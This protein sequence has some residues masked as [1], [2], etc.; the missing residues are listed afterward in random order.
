M[1]LV[2]F[3]MAM[4]AM[5]QT[6]FQIRGKLGKLPAPAKIYIGYS[7]EGKSVY[8]SADIDNGTF[9]LRQD[10]PYPVNALLTV[11][12]DGESKNFFTSKNIAHLYIEPGAIIWIT[13]DENLSHFDSNGSKSQDDYKVYEKFMAEVDIKL[14]LLTAE[15]SN[16][17]QN[18]VSQKG[19]AAK[20]E[21]M[22]RFRVAM[23][24]RK[25][26][27]KDFVSHYPDMYVSLDILDEYAGNFVDYRDVEPL[28]KSLNDRTKATVK[29]KAFLK[30]INDS[31]QTAVGAIAP[32][33]T[34][35]DPDGN[36]ISLSSF[37]GKCVLLNFWGSWS[38]ISRVE[39]QELKAIEKEFNNLIVINI[40]LEERKEYWVKAISEDRMTGYNTSDM[41]FMKNEVAELYNVTALPQNVL[42]DPS[43]KIAARNLKG[44]QLLDKIDSIIANK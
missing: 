26:K 33:F 32:D 1:F 14:A 27:M 13:S 41:R 18:D 31:R 19:L 30:K 7:Y 21:Y 36:K 8:D 4:P 37:K 40:A 24:E 44:N 38:A 15:S 39:N 11:S 9:Q 10:V 2:A 28:Y 43:G 34:Q 12:R 6:S 35:K 17:M 20:K 23:D 25:Q 5:A 29:G 16:T 42:I 3:F 22:E